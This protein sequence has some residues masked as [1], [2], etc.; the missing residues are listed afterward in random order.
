MPVV[1]PKVVAVFIEDEYFAGEPCGEHPFPFGHDGLGRANDADDAVSV[2]AEFLV[3]LLARRAGGIIRD[4][5]D[6]ASILAEVLRHAAV[7]G[8]QVAGHFRMIL[9]EDGEQ[10]FEQIAA[11]A[12]DEQDA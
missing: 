2:G 3:E 7:A 5:V 12:L 10:V 8:D 6:R 4:A 1:H 11:S 9:I